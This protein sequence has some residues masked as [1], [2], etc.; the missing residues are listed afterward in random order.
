MTGEKLISAGTTSEI[1]TQIASEIENNDPGY[2][3]I[4]NYESRKIFLEIDIDPGGG[5]E[6]GYQFT[7]IKSQLFHC[8]EFRFSM[9]HEGLL[10]E[11]GKFFGSEDIETGYPEFD[12]KVVVKTNN[13]EK[14]KSVFADEDSRKT[15][16]NFTMFKFHTV[17]YKIDETDNKGIFL[18]LTIEEAIT[19]MIF[20]QQVFNTFYSVLKKIETG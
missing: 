16:E 15:I 14:I 17:E 19:D 3:F 12:K 2:S 4:I 11:I 7:K 20:L 13:A 1:W 18:E 5:F 6:G 10:D 9:H 8:G